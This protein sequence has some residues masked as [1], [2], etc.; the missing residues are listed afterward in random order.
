MS[1]RVRS[2]NSNYGFNRNSHGHSTNKGAVNP[3]KLLEQKLMNRE[4]SWEEFEQQSRMLPS[5][6]RVKPE[7]ASV[8]I[9]DFKNYD[10]AQD[11]IQERI[12]VYGS[13]DVYTSS[14]EYRELYPKL[15]SLRQV[16]V[17]E[18][19]KQGQVA[20]MEVGIKE[21]DLV[22]YV[23]S[24]PWSMTF[25]RKGKVKLDADGIPMVSL[26]QNDV[27]SKK[28]VRWHKGYIKVID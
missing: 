14:E 28:Q 1:Y 6:T 8:E 12:I 22:E 18:Q 2:K 21:G 23:Q 15:N 3:R 10:E 24:N 7:I 9:P 5:E 11:F 27:D 25:I 4:I 16:A 26:V 19:A 20:M 13:K 17:N